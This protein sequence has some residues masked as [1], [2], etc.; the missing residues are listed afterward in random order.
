MEALDLQAG[1]QQMAGEIG[2]ELAAWRVAHPRA[3]LREIEAAVQGAVERL[4]ARYLTDLV[5][6]S[7]A[8]EGECPGAAGQ[9]PACRDGELRP[10]GRQT[11]AVLTP[12][13]RHPLRLERSYLVCSACG[14][15][16]FPP[17]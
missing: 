11:R 9:C 5:Q 3:T 7:P 15:G 16:V 6:T 4:Q 1:W 13:Q 8:A 12:R 17:G 14:S 10:R 2:D